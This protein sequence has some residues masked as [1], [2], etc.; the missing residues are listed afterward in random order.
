MV[1]ISVCFLGC[2]RINQ[3]HI[4][5]VKRLRPH[6][7]LAVAGRDTERSRRYAAENGVATSYGRYEDAIAA[8]FD[9]YVVG[10]VP[11]SHAALVES[12]L[13]AGKHCLLEKPAFNSIEEFQELWPRLKASRGV[14]MVAENLHF[15]PFQ[16][17]LKR[18]LRESPFGRPFL[19]ELI[20]LGRSAPQGWRADPAAMPLGALHEGGV[21]WI[22]R[23]LDL[24]SALEPDGRANVTEVMAYAPDASLTGMPYEDTMMVVARH[25]SG[26]TSR[27]LHTWGIPW[28]FLPFDVSKFLAE[29]GALYFDGRGIYGRSYLPGAKRML[30]PSLTDAGGYRAMWQG[31][32]NSVE[33]RLPAPLDLQT[34]YEDFAYMDAGYRSARS[35][36]PERPAPLPK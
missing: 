8:G 30:W 25:A 29:H 36:R 27:L 32:L 13:A 17:R 35:R 34:I 3:R 9:V 23:L 33:N 7:R 18:T 2:G 16:A 12:I 6:A 1:P 21:H 14:F 19:L 24:A 15:A 22:R 31:F 11:G 28:R 4:G 26:L 20:R 10:T 5:L